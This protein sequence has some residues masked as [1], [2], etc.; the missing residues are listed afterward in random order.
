MK[1]K[2][3]LDVEE[4]RSLNRIKVG[5]SI[6]FNAVIGI[7][8]QN[9]PCEIEDFHFEGVKILLPAHF[10]ISKTPLDLS[11]FELKYGRKT[12]TRINNPK[13]IR[14]VENSHIILT[15][16]TFDDAR[17]TRGKN[18]LHVKPSFRPIL[19]VKDPIKIDVLINFN[20]INFNAHGMLLET[21]LSNKHLISGLELKDVTVVLPGIAI[22]NIGLKIMHVKKNEDHIRLG[23]S[24]VDTTDENIQSLAQFAIFGTLPPADRRI[25]SKYNEVRENVGP[26]KR[27][28]TSV[29][30]ETLSTPQDY[31]SVLQIRYEAYRAAN[32][33]DQSATV[34]SMADE[35]DERSLIIIAKIDGAIVA[36]LRLVECK[37]PDERFPFEKFIPFSVIDKEENRGKYYEVCRLA[38]DPKF[39][40]TDILIKLFRENG[41]QT[42]INRKTNVCM[43][44]KQLRKNYLQLGFKVVSEEIPHPVLKNESL[45]LL[46]IDPDNFLKGKGMSVRAWD[47]VVSDVVDNLAYAEIIPKTSPKISRY[48]LRKIENLI[49][50]TSKRFRKKQKIPIT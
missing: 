33:L 39:Q 41:R 11:Y 3:S 19:M 38:I 27:L 40:G 22:L 6:E 46:A 45:A 44:T 28:G 9:L 49:L 12:L 1:K 32:K 30:I 48:F 10:E 21:S 37:T 35:F 50:K 43:S 26:L 36:T 5:P 25:S 16:T 4:K 47:L 23:V 14:A 24:L 42:G 34:E 2:L 18:R 20:L 7:N 31:M 17:G 13:V 15:F 8:G 29:R